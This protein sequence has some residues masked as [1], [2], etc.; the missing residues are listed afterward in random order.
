MSEG[1]GDE[2]FP[3]VGNL[4]ETYKLP[5]V[6]WISGRRIDYQCLGVDSGEKRWRSGGVIVGCVLKG[7]RGEND[8]RNDNLQRPSKG[9]AGTEFPIWEAESFL[10]Y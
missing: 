7:E 8:G 1:R 10:Y 9:E 5:Q 2:S 4:S 6:E 3:R